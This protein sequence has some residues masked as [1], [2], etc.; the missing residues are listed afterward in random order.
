MT[1]RVGPDE[2]D[3]APEFRNSYRCARCS[4]GWQ[5]VWTATCD[6]DCPSCGARHMGPYKS[7]DVDGN[8]LD[9]EEDTDDDKD[10]EADDPRSLRDIADDESDALG[11]DPYHHA[12]Y[13]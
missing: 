11:N 13:R 1:A 8:E 2:G 10:D 7:E 6:D 3:D 12:K 9:D 5:D 4:H